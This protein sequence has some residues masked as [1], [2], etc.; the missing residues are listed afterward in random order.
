MVIEVRTYRLLPGTR[1][2]FVRTMEQVLPLLAEFGI[3]VVSHGASLVDEDGHECAY[4]VRRFPSLDERERLED[5]FYSS[6][7]WRLG[8]R[9]AIVSRIADCHTVVL[10][11]AALRG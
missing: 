6:D 4:L 1:D 11:E 7:A 5:A 8:P 2:D 9:E 3:E 10:D